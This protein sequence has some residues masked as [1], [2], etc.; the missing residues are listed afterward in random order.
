MLAAQAPEKLE[1]REA[2]HLQVGEHQIRRG[3]VE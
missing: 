2:R 1:A 3:P